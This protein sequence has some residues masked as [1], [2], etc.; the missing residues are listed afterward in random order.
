[1]DAV[2]RVMTAGNVY[3]KGKHSASQLG[4]R[5]LPLAQ[6]EPCVLAARSMTERTAL[7]ICRNDTYYAACYDRLR[8][9][10]GHGHNFARLMTGYSPY[11]QPKWCGAHG[12]DATVDLSRHTTWQTTS[13]SLTSLF[14]HRLSVDDAA[15][16]D[17]FVASAP[18]GHY[19]QTRSWT[20]VAVASKPVT[21]YYFLLRK[22]GHVIGAALVLRARLGG[23]PLPIAQV[24]RGPVCQRKEDL[25]EV[26][27]ALKACTLRHGI[28]RLSVMPY[29]TEEPR[30]IDSWLEREGFAD[31]Q[32]FAG[33]HARSLRIDL[34]EI[35]VAEPFAAP[36]LAKVRQAIRRAERAGASARQAQP[37]DL[38]A[39]RRMHEELLRLS[40]KS[41]PGEAWYA[42]LADY[43]F[44]P[45]SQGA[46]FVSEFEG[47]IIAAVLIPRHDGLATYAMG[48]SSGRNFKFPKMILPLAHAIVW[49]KQVG[50]RSF[51]LGGIPLEG[52]TDPKRASIAEF[53]Y[54][55]SHTEIS[56]VHEH[57]RWF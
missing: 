56:L 53:K 51:D 30:V 55:F 1:M 14:S 23:L 4:K 47:E 7:P 10:L 48:A 5:Q 26:L 35:A 43:F 41:L 18:S 20:P 57:V 17:A 3:P 46:V 25:P 34:A 22:D 42:A 32:S 21:P 19:S 13:P 44:A 38:V 15:D 16:Y 27:D 50:A 31:H 45:A 36:S 6:P 9:L 54:G 52:D 12:M 33:R 40:G 28:A 24:E 49:A 8:Q 39:F 11:N 29:W 37:S 2:G